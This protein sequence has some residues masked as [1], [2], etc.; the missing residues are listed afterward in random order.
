M[1]E[2]SAPAESG[3]NAWRALAVILFLVLLVGAF[4]VIAAM[5]DISSTPTCHDVEAHLAAPKDNSCFDGTSL[6]KTI[7]VTLG[8]AGGALGAIAAVLALAFAITGRRG[9]LVAILAIAAVV[10]SGL[11]ILIGSV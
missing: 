1:E 6:Q 5:V 2:G 11:S 8:F 10:L 3:G 7:S 4:I 9:R